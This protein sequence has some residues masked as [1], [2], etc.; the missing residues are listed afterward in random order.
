MV[1]L[2]DKESGARIGV[3]SD[4][5]LQ[6]LIDQLEEESE[7]DQDYFVDG[8]TLDLLQQAGADHGLMDLLRAALGSREGMEVEWTRQ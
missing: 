2:R 3:I 6:F 8:A 7:D 1:E 4:D 5:Q